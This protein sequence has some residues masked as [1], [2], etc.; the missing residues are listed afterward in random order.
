[1]K[2]NLIVN[3]NQVW[4]WHTFL[5]RRLADDGHY[6]ALVPAVAAEPLPGAL[7]LLLEL[8][9]M[10]YKLPYKLSG[11]M[12][13]ASVDQPNFDSA[14]L[15]INLTDTNTT[16]N[17]RCLRVLYD[18]LAGDTP[19]FA[20]L[21]DGRPPLV[22]VMDVASSAIIGQA[23]PAVNDLATI[24]GAYDSIATRLVDLIA[25]TV[26]G[27]VLV[28]SP[29]SLVAPPGGH[30]G[31]SQIA[32]HC[33][34]RVAVSAIK[35][36]YKLCCYSPHWRVCWRHCNDSSVL[37]SHALEPD[38]WTQL[39]D[40]GFHFYADPFPAQ[41]NGRQF[42]FF[43]D[44]DHHTGKGIISAIEFGP[45]GPVGPVFP[46]LEESWHMSYPFVFEHEGHH[47]MIPETSANNT[48][49]LYRADRFPG[50]WTKEADILTGREYSDATIVKHDGRLWMFVTVR[51][52]GAGSWSDALHVFHSDSLFGPW[53]SIVDGPVIIDA[54]TARSAGC[55]VHLNG[56]IWR[57]VQDCTTGYGTGIGLCQVT[58]LDTQGF[59]QSLKATIRPPSKWPGGRLH[60]LNR[61]GNLELIDGSAY[62]PKIPLIARGLEPLSGRRQCPATWV[63]SERA[64]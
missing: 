5:Q 59:E 16:G 55:M 51:Q 56:Q 53:Q 33:A 35:R 38:T 14:D 47:W 57:P 44:L 27:R 62:S 45:A 25:T 10:L 18:G 32:A 6:C 12:A 52:A 46:V 17:G 60:T 40:P 58:R 30:L 7:S 31:T 21:I 39:P 61:L 4:R 11:T 43:E 2:I 64:S 15:T 13:G 49:S 19:A 26:R 48:V 1:M 63:E 8:E 36:L 23:R 41:H 20:A 22:E 50:R 34:R 9:R 42:V 29:S 37:T 24:S 54:T 3:P 28:T